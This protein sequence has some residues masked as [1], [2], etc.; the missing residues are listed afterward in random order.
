[1][2]TIVYLVHGMGCGSAN[3]APR[4][5]SD[6]WSRPVVA[7]MQWLASTFRLPAPH[8][9]DPLPDA[10]PPGSDAPDALWLVPVSYFK[11]FDEFRAS[12]A[13]RAQLA[14][15][16]GGLTDADATR[17]ATMDFAWQNCLDVFLWWADRAE[18]RNWATT[19]VLD[20]IAG[21][22]ALAMQIPGGATR[23]VLISHSLGTAVSTYALRHLGRVPAWAS[24]GAFDAWFTLANVAPFLLEARDVYA[25]PLVPG[26][27]GALVAGHMFNARNEF[28]PIPWLI[29]RRVFNPALAGVAAA[30]WTDA[31]SAHR[32]HLVT[33]RGL[34]APPGETPEIT[35]V[36]GFANYLMTPGVAL[37]LAGLLRGSAFTNDE[38]AE[39]HWPEAWAQLPA[40]RCTHSPRALD[41]LRT[42]VTHFVDDAARPG[43]AP[44]DPDHP[45]IG[46]LLRGAE[47][48]AA[49]ADRC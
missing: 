31:A 45:W 38:L 12:S 21:A 22:D 29:P 33:T 1:M 35:Q 4:A 43:T 40:L 26:A 39:R 25:P 28:D 8:V 13:D 42:A 49:A 19:A 46:R 2:P 10:P 14:A 11:V 36:H 47:L 37:P 5:S 3:G 32:Y 17:L 7:A 16:I 30:A 24:R 41:E 18:A 27:P 48:L 20:A 9:L 6:V 34:A 23:R 15:A 44:G